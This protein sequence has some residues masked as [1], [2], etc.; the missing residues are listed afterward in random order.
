MKKSEYLFDAN[1]LKLL[2]HSCAL[3][4]GVLVEN[5]NTQILGGLQI[6]VAAAV[7]FA[8]VDYI[9][10]KILSDRALDDCALNDLAANSAKM[11][12]MVENAENLPKDYQPSYEA[13]IYSSGVASVI[14]SVIDDD[15]VV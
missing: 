5:V 15:P 14:S 11:I 10:H 1:R 4:D 7:I 12:S 13:E 9:V 6:S 2:A 3:Y 8:D